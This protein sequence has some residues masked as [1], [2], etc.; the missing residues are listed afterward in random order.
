MKMGARKIADFKVKGI[1]TMNAMVRW[2]IASLGILVF[3]FA[4]AEGEV[5]YASAGNPKNGDDISEYRAGLMANPYPKADVPTAAAG[6]YTFEAKGELGVTKGEGIIS[7]RFDIDKPIYNITSA[8]VQINAWDVDYPIDYSN[9]EHDV[10]YFNNSKIGRLTGVNN[11]WQKNTFSVKASKINVPSSSGEIVKNSLDIKVD[12]G[13]GDWITQIGYATLTIKGELRGFDAPKNFKATD[14]SFMSHPLGVYLSWD[15][16]DNAKYYNVYRDVS[17]NGSWTYLKTVTGGWCLDLPI[18]GQK[19]LAANYRVCVASKNSVNTIDNAGN[20]MFSQ[21]NNISDF[22]N[23]DYGEW[24]YDEKPE[25][26]D[27]ASNGSAPAHIC[28]GD[29]WAFYV[30]LNEFSDEL[31]EIVGVEVTA[32]RFNPS[33]KGQTLVSRACQEKF[34]H[35]YRVIIDIP[36]QDGHGD[37]TLSA[38]VKYKKKDA[39]WGTTSTAKV[40]HDKILRVFF[41]GEEDDGLPL[42]KMRTTEKNGVC[43]NWFRYWNDYMDGTIPSLDKDV[44]FNVNLLGFGKYNPDTEII[45]VGRDCVSIGK[46]TEPVSGVEFLGVTL[47]DTAA[48]HEKEHRNCEERRYSLC[49][50][51]LALAENG[52]WAY[53]GYRGWYL[54]PEWMQRWDRDGDGLSYDFELSL[55]SPTDKWALA[56]RPFDV[57]KRDTFGFANGNT[58]W[59]YA[60]EEVYVRWYAAKN[61]TANTKRDWSYGG[62]LDEVNIHSFLGKWNFRG[63]WETVN[64]GLDV[65]CIFTSQ[66]ED[67][68]GANSYVCEELP[69]YFNSPEIFSS[70]KMRMAGLMVEKHGKTKPFESLRVSFNCAMDDRDLYTIK[71]YLVDAETNAVARG[72]IN[73]ELS[74]IVNQVVIDFDSSILREIDKEFFL[75]GLTVERASDELSLPMVVTN[76]VSQEMFDKKDFKPDAIENIQLKHVEKNEDSLNVLYVIDV[77]RNAT[78]DI[79][80]TLYTDENVFVARNMQTN[81]VLNVGMQEILLRFPNK[82]LYESQFTNS[83]VSEVRYRTD[84]ETKCFMLSNI[85]DSCVY[86]DFRTTNTVVELMVSSVTNDFPILDGGMVKGVKIPFDIVNHSEET[87]CCNIKGILTDTNHVFKSQC[88]FDAEIKPGV[89]TLIAEFALDKVYTGEYFLEEIS[90]TPQKSEMQSETYR[91]WYKTTSYHVGVENISPISMVLEPCLLPIRN[92]SLRLNIPV[93]FLGEGEADVHA[94]ILDATGKFVASASSLSYNFNSGTNEIP[95]VFMMDDILY[96]KCEMPCRIGAISVNVINGTI[97]QEVKKDSRLR[98]ESFFESLSQ[99]GLTYQLDASDGGLI[100]TNNYGNV[101]K[102]TSTDGRYEFNSDSSVKSLYS[103]EAFNGKGAIRFG[104]DFIGGTNAST[105]LVTESALDCQTVFIVCKPD[106][107]QNSYAGIWGQDESVYGINFSGTSVF[108]EGFVKNGELYLNG[109]YCSD[110]GRFTPGEPLIITAVNNEMQTFDAA[111][112][113]IHN[114]TNYPARYFKGELAEIIAYNRKL[115]AAERKEVELHLK[116]KW[117]SGVEEVSI[118]QE[119]M[120]VTAAEQ[121]VGIDVVAFS[122][123]GLV[124]NQGWV[125]PSV[126]HG[127]GTTNISLQV[128]ANTTGTNRT[129]FVT[130]T[131]TVSSYTF[132]LVQYK[133]GYLSSDIE[134]QKPVTISASSDIKTNGEL[135]YAYC[136]TYTPTVNGVKFNAGG[137][138]AGC[139][140]FG[141]WHWYG[142]TYACDD[143]KPSSSL[144]SAYRNLLKGAM[145][146]DSLYINDL[147]VGQTYM[148]QIWCNNSRADGVG[149]ITTLTSGANSCSLLGNSTGAY[150][151]I[152]QYVIGYFVADSTRKTIEIAGGNQFFNAIQ[153]R[154]VPE[155]QMPSPRIM[156]EDSVAPTEDRII[157]F[158]GVAVG[159]SRT[160]TITIRNND[161]I[162]PL[163]LKSVSTRY[164]E[165]FDS[166]AAEGWLPNGAA[167]WNV[168]AGVYVAGNPTVTNF[169][170]SVYSGATYSDV[171]V[172]VDVWRSEAESNSQGILLRASEDGSSGY[173]FFITDN[174]SYSVW[175]AKGSSTT[176]LQGWTSSSAI[177]KG[178]TNTVL[179]CAMGSRLSFYINGKLVWTGED[180]TIKNGKI[181]VAGYVDAAEARFFFDNVVQGAPIP[182]SDTAVSVASERTRYIS[183]S[184]RK[185]IFEKD[186]VKT[187]E[188]ISNENIQLNVG[189]DS[190]LFEVSDLPTLPMQIAPNEAV[191][192]S[193]TFKPQFIGETGSDVRIVTDDSEKPHLS[194][195]VRGA[196]EA[197]KI[198]LLPIEP[199]RID[200]TPGGPFN[201]NELIYTVTNSAESVL[202]WEFVNLPE[203]LTPKTR[204]GSLPGGSSVDV[205]FEL[206][207]KANLLVKGVY[208]GDVT[209]RNKTTSLTTSRVVT[210]ILKESADLQLSSWDVVVTNKIGMISGKSVLVGNRVTADIPLAATITPIETGRTEYVDPVVAQAQMKSSFSGGPTGTFRIPAGIEFRKQEL[211]VKFDENAATAQAQEAKLAALGGGEVVRRYKLVPGLALIRIP[212]PV[213]TTKEMEELVQRFEATTGISYVQPNYEQKALAIPNDP[214][215]EELYAMRNVGQTGG[216]SG[217]DI[218][219]TLA[220]DRTT[221]NESVIVGVIDSGVDYNHED[222]AANM[223]INSG[224]VPG[225]GI[226]NDGNGVVDDVYGYNSIEDSGDPMDDNK[227]GTHCAGTIAAVGNNGIGVAGVCWTARIMALKFLD[228]NGRGDTANA[229]ACIEYAVLN[230]AKILSNSWGGGAYSYALKEMIDAAGK[231]GVLFVAAAGNEGTNNDVTPHYPSSYSCENIIAVLSVDH[232]D[233][234][235]SSSCYGLESVDIAAPGV[236]ILSCYVGG[237]YVKLSGTSMATPHVSGAAALLLSVNQGM[238]PY[239]IKETLMNSGDPVAEG[240]CVSGKRLNVA[241]ALRS[242]GRWLSVS[243]E[244]IENL[245]PGTQTDLGITFDAGWCEPGVYDGIVRFAS[246]DQNKPVTNLTVRMVVEPDDLRVSPSTSFDV[247]GVEGGPFSPTSGVYRIRNASSIPVSWAVATSNSWMSVSPSEGVIPGGGSQDVVVTVN[248]YELQDY[249]QGAYTAELFIE[250]RN[251]GIVQRR[252]ANLTIRNTAG[253]LYVDPNRPDDSGSGR[254]WRSAKKTL[255]SAI[256]KAMDGATIVVTN[257]VYSPIDTRGKTLTI[258]SVNGPLETIIDGQNQAQCAILGGSKYVSGYRVFDTNVVVSG[259]TLRNGRAERKLV[260]GV[261][262]GDIYGGGAYGGVLTNCYLIGNYATYGAGA[263][264]CKLYD[265]LVARNEASYDGGGLYICDAINCRIEYNRAERGAGM[266]QGNA[267]GCL[268]EHN[269]SVSYG[270][271]IY[272]GTLLNCTVVD[273]KCRSYGGAGTYR[274]AMTNSIVWGNVRIS[275]GATYNTDGGS[276]VRSCIQTPDSYYNA[277]TTLDSYSISSDP[278]FVDSDSGIY[279]LSSLSPCLNRGVVVDNLTSVDM[280]GRAR[281]QDGSPDCGAYEGVPSGYVIAGAV[282]GVGLIDRR[283]ALVESG[284][285][286][287]FAAIAIDRD[288]DSFLVDGAEVS[289]ST[290]YEWGNV[291]S[292]GKIVARFRNTDIFVDANRP[293]DSGDGKTWMTA[294]RTLNGAVNAVYEGENIIVTNGIYTAVN[295]LGKKIVLRSVEGASK[296]I[297]DGGGTN[298]CANL[299]GTYVVMSEYGAGSTLM[300]FTLR[301]GYSAS[302]AG[303]AYYGTLVNCIVRDNKAETLGGG[304]YYSALTNCVIASNMANIGG[305]IYYGRMFN[306]S[307][308]GNRANKSNSGV[309]GS[310][311]RDSVIWGNRLRN[312]DTSDVQS[313]SFFN[314]YVENPSSMS[315]AIYTTDPGLVDPI[316]GDARLR[317]GS[318]CID[319]GM[320]LS[321]FPLGEYDVVMK[322]RVCGARVDIGAYEGNAVDG[323][324]ISGSVSGHGGLVSNTAV[325]APGGTAVFTALPSKRRFLGFMTNGVFVATS[326]MTFEWINITSDGTIKAVYEKVDLYVDAK[327]PDDTGT[328]TSW[329]T[330]YKSLQKAVDEALDDEVVYVAAGVYD[331]IEVDDKF[332]LIKSVSGAADTV[333]DGGGKTR[334]AK[335]GKATVHHSVIMDGFTF[336]NGFATQGAGVQ[337]GTLTNCIVVA[338]VA[339]GSGYVYGGGTYYSDL[340][341]CEVRDNVARGSDAYAGGCYYGT[342]VNCVIVGNTAETT[343]RWAYGGG[344]HYGTSIGCLIA[345]NSIKASETSS[346]SC[347][348][349]G[350]CYGTLRNCTVAGNR[351][352]AGLTSAGVYN[353]SIY[354]SIV[355]ENRTEANVLANHPGSSMYYSCSSPRPS[356]TSNINS[357]PLFIDNGNGNYQLQDNSPCINRGYNSYVENQVDLLGN[358]RIMNTTVDMGAYEWMG[359]V[360]MPVITPS[361]G[362]IFKG[363]AQKVMITCNTDDAIIYYTLD[364]SEPTRDSMIYTKAFNIKETTTIKAKAFAEQM[365]ASK[366]ATSKITKFVYSGNKE[367]AEALDVPDWEVLTDTSKPWVKVGNVSSDN[368]DSAKCGGIGDSALSWMQTTV[369]GKGTLSFVWKTSCEDDPDFDDWDYVRFLVDDVEVVR[370]DG[371]DDWSV[372]EVRLDAL[373]THVLR[374]EYV[375]DSSGAEGEDCVWVDNVVWIKDPEPIPEIIKDSEVAAALEGSADAKLTANITDAETYAAYRTWALGLAGVT[376]DAVKASPNAWLSYALNTAALIAAAPKEGDL[377]IGGFTQGSLAGVFDLSVSISGIT[378]GDNATAANLEKVFGVEGAGSLD[379]GEFK[380]ANVDIEFGKPDGGKVKIKV[381]P[382][383]MTA[384]QVFMRV[385]MK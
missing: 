245:E 69:D 142:G 90:V 377:K 313:G 34:P 164:S 38:N 220:W 352:P 223:W 256:A 116:K 221:G 151:G 126:A 131:N 376:P 167:D 113:N 32:N 40:F 82:Q 246:N 169:L 183:K 248:E 168:V 191:T 295:T 346:L 154:K 130:V 172:Q 363:V 279:L 266:Y 87:I 253:V 343:T 222:L 27:I 345:N 63:S 77:Q 10:V 210:L 303:G 9:P 293:D 342:R 199:Y 58:Y 42:K 96:E 355:W 95:V 29:S 159:L 68:D 148:V 226:D 114:N 70:N 54:Y 206:N 360:T 250:N 133:S 330:A 375:K 384:K 290:V 109:K 238:T 364:G 370:K 307:I 97:F 283:I 286:A 8:S 318:P 138:D 105:R 45:E 228:A 275:D 349:G 190:D 235:A 284:G 6:T 152:G 350:S 305:G 362:A 233:R 194:V 312:C 15:T 344:V 225:D 146:A 121:N 13:D 261:Y 300:G 65:S 209:V 25:I 181:G 358:L 304:V 359:T 102:W 205:T 255:N 310:Y 332:I 306:C 219:A 200:G 122:E 365:W 252:F 12:I 18:Q 309:Y 315:S 341:S 83:I 348:G 125:I 22:S 297:I 24:W 64:E 354:N 19:H 296:T 197:D 120:L 55:G 16:V 67:I 234:R 320:L 134:F 62:Y 319:K 88:V 85:L 31:Y 123:W 214:R 36:Y 347:Y 196:G 324:V 98:I 115:S 251:N 11:G 153:L 218:S 165:D 5:V 94:V 265:C 336:T 276:A 381:T 323:Y 171:A 325:V 380:E 160:E 139:F 117:I 89:G 177:V 106:G 135:V 274:S 176:S 254:S 198:G 249:P 101:V 322:P 193:V 268:I 44:R 367:L 35:L 66:N 237:G 243:K 273:N 128:T 99:E 208:Y 111:L 308:V 60:D 81:L 179:A 229:L 326:N 302:T 92:G 338:N 91:L 241:R 333:V 140:S 378:V 184:S 17:N 258:R 331:P 385:K 335:L 1:T 51:K 301:N 28:A 39:W 282:D 203:W 73:V 178:G 361:D 3:G 157:D 291:T 78:F 232:N 107:S 144:P 337:Y 145:S 369:I 215:F 4:K 72:V 79:L 262:E 49:G 110:D 149:K 147:E 166:G 47:V 288:F 292:N 240:L 231:Q 127:T 280:L 259:F 108:K 379:E 75:Y 53:K 224:E 373:K 56:S 316:N 374:W 26:W 132:K 236:N 180:N 129:A 267:V 311:C 372:V 317:V 202:E 161:Q 294:K 57:T 356:G 207:E 76:F 351:V 257:G 46:Y 314:C 368:E 187:E 119:D 329:S 14:L 371:V 170:T 173:E 118:A 227:H 43:Y 158:G 244:R 86:S 71:A 186:S 61:P 201:Q 100:G 137:T 339:S 327:R 212:V 189:I 230:G 112:G 216:T 278:K 211:L 269:R 175:C 260:N 155:S 247:Y 204:T 242:S 20:L 136:V 163:T 192:F 298:R 217:C 141:N 299:T 334:C 285:T 174:G 48:V 143:A 213:A 277:K 264:G 357:N 270:G 289:K 124:S 188:P 52:A 93:V 150:G 50:K 23:S 383:D 263:Y 21:P 328:G 84:S 2:M 239:Q 340:Y 33:R 272:L 156:I 104:Y 103:Q 321:N 195:A 80:G 7:L 382:K 281:V 30:R 41:M 162:S 74:N 271:G 182:G 59:A 287:R 366:I 37:Y 185:M 353:G